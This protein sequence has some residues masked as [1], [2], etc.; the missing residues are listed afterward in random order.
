M[1][2][3]L[4]IVCLPKKYCKS[5]SRVTAKACVLLVSGGTKVERQQILTNYI[6]FTIA[7]ICFKDIFLQRIHTFLLTR[8]YIFIG[9]QLENAVCIEKL[10]L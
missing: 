3:V 8:N 1:L 4:A 6:C 5:L 7:S 9:G 10:C 2:F